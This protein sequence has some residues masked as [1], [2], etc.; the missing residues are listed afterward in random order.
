VCPVG[1]SVVSGG[2][3]IIPQSTTPTVTALISMPVQQT[4][5]QGAATAPGP[6]GWEVDVT[7][8]PTFYDYALV[9]YAI[10]AS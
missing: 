9:A 10:C 5:P 3:K 2:Y 7:P 6:P 4:T 8:E 1:D